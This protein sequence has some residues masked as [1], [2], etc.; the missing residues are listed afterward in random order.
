MNTYIMHT[1]LGRKR[2][3]E[4]NSNVLMGSQREGDAF[5]GEKIKSILKF[6][7]DTSSR[8]TVVMEYIYSGSRSDYGV[9][10]LPN[11]L[12]VLWPCHQS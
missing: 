2:E 12:M 8:S 9:S 4:E 7:M 5:Q 6:S 1:H 3:G 11:S 10:L